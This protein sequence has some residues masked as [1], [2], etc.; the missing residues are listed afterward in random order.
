ME[1]GVYLHLPLCAR[2]CG[3][4]DFATVVGED[5]PFERY[6]EKLVLEAT[7]R[8]D[9]YRRWPLS[10][11]YFGGGSPSL[12]QPGLLGR[13]VRQLSSLFECGETVE[14]TAELNPQDASDGLLDGYLAA[15]INRLSIGVQSLDDEVLRR[16]T[17]EHDAATSHAA[18][19]AARRAGFDNI[20]CDMI[21]GIAGQTV[22]H[23]LD[24]TRRLLDWQPDHLSLY[25]LTLA[26]NSALWRQGERPVD[27]DASAAMLEA[28]RDVLQAAGFAQ[29]EVSNYAR[30]GRVAVHNSC[31]WRGYPYLGLGAS[32]H[33]LSV[34]RD[35][36]VRVRNPPFSRYLSGP[37]EDAADPN[38][39]AVDGALVEQL[40]A[41]HSEKELLLLGLRTRRGVDRAFYRQRFGVDPAE[42]YR[43]ALASFV[44]AGMLEVDARA[45][46]PT[47]RGI[48]LADELTVRL[49]GYGKGTCD[50][51]QAG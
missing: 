8:A 3:Y 42:R 46:R 18:Y 24:Q 1:L 14:V 37:I 11:I 29:Y 50:D 32:A 47:A 28:G 10:S 30:G 44:R 38:L 33:S 5:F 43:A 13:L 26:K 31:V 15:G 23:H 35:R 49:F 20:S 25:Q 17:R 19:L 9:A 36:H 51:G 41:A 12:W 16:L 2:R 45:I 21:F 48:W 27:D 34:V 22:E 4:C 6:A 7:H 40:D 39:V